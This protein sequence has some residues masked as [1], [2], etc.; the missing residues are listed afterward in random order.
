MVRR[1]E[2]TEQEWELLAPSIPRSATGRPRV[3]DRQGINGM[4]Y[5]IR[6]GIS[7]RDL[8]RM[9]RTVADGLYPRPPLRDQRG[10]HPGPAE[11]PGPGRCRR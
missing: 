9:L 7:W 11:D 4:V 2:L 5:K 10:V 3:S 6:T 8:A 1:H